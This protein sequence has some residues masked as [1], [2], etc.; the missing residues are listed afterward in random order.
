MQADY[1]QEAIPGCG[2]RFKVM[3]DGREIGH[4]YLYL[5]RNDLH[6]VPFGLVEDV[7][8]E[9]D[10]RGQGLGK[11]LLNRIIEEAKVRHCYKLI[12][13]CRHSNKHLHNF[14]EQSGFTNHGFEFRMDL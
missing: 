4:S 14:Y 7:F 10:F 6:L 8:I 1:Q 12:L 5:L 13:T 9:A 3:V 2:V 11:F